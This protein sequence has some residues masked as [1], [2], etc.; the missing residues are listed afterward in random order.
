[1][2]KT[3]QMRILVVDDDE[4]IRAACL[5]IL[6]GAGHE[7]TVTVNGVAALQRL[8]S[9]QFDLVLADIEM[10]MLDGFGLYSTVLQD[11]P[12]LTGR[13][14]FITGRMNAAKE[15]ILSKWNATY[16]LKPFSVK[17]LLLRVGAFML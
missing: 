3:N 16:I 7:V 14:L 6:S 12:Y 8:K 5:L 13:F 4:F 1:M 9:A 15:E 2:A 17:E 11:Y 10:P